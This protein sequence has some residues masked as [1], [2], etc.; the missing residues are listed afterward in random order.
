M[1]N[2]IHKRGRENSYAI[3]QAKKIAKLNTGDD[4]VHPFNKFKE[5]KNIFEKDSTI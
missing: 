1:D 3:K 4:L 5:I 2:L